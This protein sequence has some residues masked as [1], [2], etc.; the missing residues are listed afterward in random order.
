MRGQ[1]P[2]VIALPIRAGLTLG[3]LAGEKRSSPATRFGARVRPARR[4]EDV[5]RG[6]PGHVPRTIQVSVLSIS[7]ALAC[8]GSPRTSGRSA[9]APAAVAGRTRRPEGLHAQ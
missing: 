8:E 5:P 6:A 9:A 4:R 1:R 7:A 3:G 2:L